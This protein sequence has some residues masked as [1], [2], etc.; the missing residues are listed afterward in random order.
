MNVCHLKNSEL[1]PPFQKCKGR[2]VLLGDFVK[3]DSGSHAAITAQVSSASQMTGAK[4]MDIKSRLPGCAGQAADAVSANTQVK[5][6][7]C[8]IIVEDSEVRMSRYLD[9]STKTQMA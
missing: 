8:T 6:G 2:V 4:V 1:E 7:R 5:N 3:D 9:T